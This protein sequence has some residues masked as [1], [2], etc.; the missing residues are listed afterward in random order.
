M[1]R[2]WIAF[3]AKGTRTEAGAYKGRTQGST[4]SPLG[5]RPT[6]LRAIPICASGYPLG[7]QRLG[8]DYVVVLYRP[9][10]MA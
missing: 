5:T 6:Q 10:F 4:H 9:R 2:K 3:G 7:R 1:S 8:R